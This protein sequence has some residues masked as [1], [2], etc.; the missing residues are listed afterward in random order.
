M[1]RL[2]VVAGTS[3]ETNVALVSAFGRAGVESALLRPEQARR[4]VRP[5]DVVLGR[6]DVLPSLEGVETC[7][8][9]LRRL[10]RFGARVLNDVGALLASHD[11]LQTALRLGRAGVPHPKTLHLDGKKP[12]PRLEPPI[13]LKPRFGSWGRDVVL[14]ESPEAV[15]HE[16]EALARR[17]WFR[18]HGVLAQELVPPAGF[19]LRVIVAGGEVVGAVERRSAPGEWRTNVAVGATRHPAA[20][21]PDARATAIAAA[22]AV[23]ADLVGVDLLPSDAGWVVLELNGA[24]DFT[25]DYSLE[26]RDVFDE[27]ARALTRERQPAALVG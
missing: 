12:L 25:T 18:R 16:L 2:F 13:V 6:V 9:E 11:K 19:D 15:E 1:T 10:E 23:G 26:G 17:R 7:L 24:V 14:C 8:W 27:V 4:R 3:T 20:P 21:P 5:G 22:A